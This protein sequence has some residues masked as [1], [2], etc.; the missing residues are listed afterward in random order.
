M[1]ATLLAV[2]VVLAQDGGSAAGAGLALAMLSVAMIAVA[3]LGGRIADRRGRRLPADAGLSLLVVSSLGLAL[4][5]ASPNAVGLAA[6]LLLGGA[7]LGLS[8]AAVQTAAMESV[9][10]RH[11]GVAAGLFST[12]RYAGAVVSA[13]LLALVLGDGTEHA[14]AFFAIASG[15]ALGAVLL[16]LR[17]GAPREGAVVAEAA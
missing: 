11:A 4:M 10:E 7:G 9:P 5:G 17:L 12:G 6:A 14:S 15:A 16:A 1:Y 8:G 13:A 2:P 3:P